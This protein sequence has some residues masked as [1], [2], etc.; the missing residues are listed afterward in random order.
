MAKVGCAEQN[1]A[2][3]CA[4]FNEAEFVRVSVCSGGFGQGQAMR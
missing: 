2:R 1:E 3:L 4:I